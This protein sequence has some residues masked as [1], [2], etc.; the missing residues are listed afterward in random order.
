MRI[1]ALTA[2][3]ITALFAIVLFP[4]ANVNALSNT[5][6]NVVVQPGDTLWGIA[7]NNSTTYSR[8]FDANPQITD[9]NV[10]YPGE[11]ITIPGPN[12][13]LP[14]RG[15]IT[16]SPASDQ[17][18]DA[19]TSTSTQ[20][21]VPILASQN[22]ST[23]AGS[24]SVWDAIAQCESSDNWSIDTGNGYY[25]GLQFT[26]SSWQAVGGTGYPNQASK[27]EQIYRASLLQQS[28]GWGAWPVCSVRAGL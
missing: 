19:S 7:N 8:L 6:N 28:Q 3:F 22:T 15:A 5:T 14:D 4:I 9:P 25:G 13:Q 23:A 20:S 2:V 26:L 27:A 1:T 17:D 16:V 18:S 21:T 24:S 10:I 12:Q 11:N